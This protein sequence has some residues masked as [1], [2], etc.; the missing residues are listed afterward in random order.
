MSETLMGHIIDNPRG[1]N[2]R[3]FSPMA[4][5]ADIIANDNHG[6][7]SR[8]VDLKSKSWKSRIK[9]FGSL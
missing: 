2:E 4:D 5:S 6:C 9:M 1:Q 3:L 7:H 8:Y